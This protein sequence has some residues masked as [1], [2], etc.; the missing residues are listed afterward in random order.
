MSACIEA[1]KEKVWQ[2]LSD[3][4]NID[5]WV[6]PII[7]ATCEGSQ[8]SGAGSIRFCHLKGNVTVKEK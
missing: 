7:S 4:S 1:P 6:G 8:T 5:L 3:V 2:V